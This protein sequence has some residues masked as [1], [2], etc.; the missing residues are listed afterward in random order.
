M[1]KKFHIVYEVTNL[2]NGMIYI[3]KRSTNKLDDGYLG[4]G[5][6]IKAAIKK[7]GRENFTR[8]ILYICETEDEAYL[9]EKNI[10][11]LEFIKRRDTYNQIP[12]GRGGFSNFGKRQSESHR[13]KI[14]I[15]RKLA[16]EK[17]PKKD[18]RHEH[19]NSWVEGY[20]I[21]CKNNTPYPSKMYKIVDPV[22][23]EY[24]VKGYIKFCRE[25]DLDRDV[26]KRRINKGI[27]IIHKKFQRSKQIKNCVGW[28][29]SLLLPIE[30]V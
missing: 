1:I 22:G 10:V 30:V 15:A 9:I 24:V 13:N 20:K 25:H 11:T 28:Q 21:W 27:I 3:G 26:F 2:I 29:I 12:G 6:G 8:K 23:R 4:S 19:H 14:A 5:F 18:R 7:Y 17:I 16:W